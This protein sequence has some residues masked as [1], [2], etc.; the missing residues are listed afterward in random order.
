MGVIRVT[1]PDG[2]RCELPGGGTASALAA[3]IG[4]RLAKAAVCAKVNGALADLAAPLHD[5]DMVEIVT[6]DSD[7]GRD[8]FRHSASHVMASAIKQLR[9]DVKLA[10]GPAIE[11]GFYYDVDADPPLTEGDLEGIE[12]EMAAIVKEDQPFARD[13]LSFADAAARFKEQDEAYKVELIEDLDAAVVSLYRNGDFV[14]LCRGPHVP[15]TG[16]IKAFKLLSLAGAYWRGDERNPMLQRVYGTA[17]PTKKQLDEHLALLAEAEKRDHR[18]LGRQ[19]DLFSFHEAGPGFP[20]FHPKGLVVLNELMAFWREEHRK[21][22]YGE[23]RTPLILDLSLWEQSGHWDHYKENMY[24][25]R[26]DDRDFAVKPMNCPGGILVYKTALRSYRDLPLRLAEVGT[27]HR[28]EKSGVLHGL[29]R[30]R[31]FTQDDAHIFMTPDQIQDEVIRIIDFVDAVYSVFGLPYRVELSTRPHNAI[32]TDAMWEAATS[33]LRNALEAKAVAYKV[34]EGDGAFYGPKIDFH[35]RD[36]LK[37]SHQCATIQLDFAMPD[38]F[39]LEYMGADGA[40]HRPVVIHRVIYGSIERFFGILLEHFGGAFPLWLAPVQVVV[41][42]VSGAFAAYAGR[43][44]D[45]LFDLGLRV[46]VDEADE[47][48][49]YRIRAA[50]TQQVP[51]MLVVGEKEERSGSVS[52][53]HRRRGDLGA[54]DL[55]AFAARVQAERVSRALDG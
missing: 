12:R 32:G 23:V 37:R 50:Q 20:F 51:Y 10:I 36:S 54:M 47:T 14:D 41:I 24:F 52:V 16:R 31:M 48:M 35:I 3:K 9:P 30:V 46:G 40:R 18:K 29:M 25:T 4:P 13:E 53:R 26:I 33:G 5:G 34:N 28:H 7:E 22:G 17:F 42:P 44:R 49:N 38:K 8:V 1:L 45:T 27:V 2:S 6:F 15:S 43:V 19:L 39:E 21:R 55:E 11:D